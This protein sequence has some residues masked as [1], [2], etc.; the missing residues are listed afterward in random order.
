MS[1]EPWCSSPCVV[2]NGDVAR[3]CARCDATFA[4]HPDAAGFRSS[5]TESDESLTILKEQ[6]N[7]VQRR[8]QGMNSEQPGMAC[9]SDE[10]YAEGPG[11]LKAAPAGHL[12]LLNLSHTRVGTV[13][14]WVEG[15]WPSSN[16]LKRWL[17]RNQGRG[18]PMLL[19]GLAK[20]MPAYTLWAT[21]AR[22]R[23]SSLSGTFVDVE[24]QRKETRQCAQA[25][26]PLDHFLDWYTRNDVHG[27]TRIPAPEEG[28]SQD[29]PLPRWLQCHR[30]NGHWN[31]SLWWMSSGMT[32]STLH[33]DVADNLNCVITGLKRWFLIDARLHHIVE[34][35]SCGWAAAGKGW[36]AVDGHDGLDEVPRAHVVERADEARVRQIA[37]DR[38]WKFTPGSPGGYGE[39]AAGIDVDAVDL[40]QFPCWSK[41][42]WREAIVEEGDCL[43]VPAGTYHHVRSEGQRNLAINTWF[44]GFDG[45]DR[46]DMAS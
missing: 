1:C 3:E 4:C 33:K 19:R 14:E 17:A 41:L 40:V 39:W 5:A 34:A 35:E 36:A 10:L 32:L 42:P 25:T 37:I 31:E 28:G 6:S 20:A 16:L 13:V 44:T 21:D 18:E 2:L 45:I 12:P 15:T 11:S 29:A 30:R 24:F 27:L 46:C 38:G 22:M 43:F 8:K 7:D 26:M 23:R 9:D